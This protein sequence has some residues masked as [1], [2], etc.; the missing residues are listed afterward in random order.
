[1]TESLDF[2]KV[3]IASDRTSLPEAGE[4]L[5]VLLDPTD[6]TLWSERVRHLWDDD[7]SR[8]RSEASIRTAHRHRDAVYTTERI[9]EAAGV[10]P[11]ARTNQPT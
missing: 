9:L 7:E 4:G 10:T 8:H 11:A 5:A 2:G 3:C 1:M 6:L